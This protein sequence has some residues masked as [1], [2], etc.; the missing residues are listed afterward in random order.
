MYG[1]ETEL[2]TVGK[3][4]KLDRKFLRRENSRAHQKSD[5][6]KINNYGIYVGLKSRRSIL[7]G[8][9]RW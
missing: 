9:Y 4:I 3:L 5:I 2:D 8:H 6:L 1:Q 7:R